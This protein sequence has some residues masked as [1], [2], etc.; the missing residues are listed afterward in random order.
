MAIN[1][2]EKKNTRNDR[3][4][5]LETSCWKIQ[6]RNERI[7]KIMGVKHT[8]TV[9]IQINQLKWYSHVRR[10]EED[11]ILKQIL[12]EHRSVEEGEENQGGA[13]EGIDKEIRERDLE[14]NLWEDR[15]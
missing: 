5:L 11:R 6:I 1:E 9:D 2:K 4:G 7:R 15:E 12:N 8:I 3:D 13:G 14:E 10:M